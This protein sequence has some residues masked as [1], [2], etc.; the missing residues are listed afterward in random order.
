MM[1]RIARNVSAEDIG[2]NSKS[3]CLPVAG[4]NT[5]V[6]VTE[7]FD[8]TSSDLVNMAA[9][10]AVRFMNQIVAEQGGLPHTFDLGLV[11]RWSAAAVAPQLGM[12][13]L[14]LLGEETARRLHVVATMLDCT[15][16]AA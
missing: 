9:G 10:E 1:H 14:K 5:I 6:F 13:E 2:D 3:P 4:S 7:F 15:K 12:Y 11:C 8:E 16:G